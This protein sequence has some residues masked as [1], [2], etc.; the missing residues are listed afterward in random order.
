[1]M[2]GQDTRL[3]ILKAIANK[4]LTSFKIYRPSPRIRKT[5]SLFQLR[6]LVLAVPLRS[7]QPRPSKFEI[8]H[9]LQHLPL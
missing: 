3:A 9:P 4:I 7:L 8:L 6:L 2:L 1:M 5:K